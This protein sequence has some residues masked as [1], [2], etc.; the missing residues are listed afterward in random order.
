MNGSLQD[1][2]TTENFPALQLLSVITLIILFGSQR[3]EFFL[4]ITM[5]FYSIVDIFD[6][7]N[8]Y[9]SVVLHDGNTASNSETYRN[10]CHI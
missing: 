4:F 1:Y 3:F 9:F 8:T 6:G 10:I 5:K 7:E 2:R